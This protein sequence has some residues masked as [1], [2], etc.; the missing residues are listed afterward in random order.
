MGVTEGDESTMSGAGLFAA[1]AGAAAAAA[2]VAVAVASSSDVCAGPSSGIVSGAEMGVEVDLRPEW[3][4]EKGDS[5]DTSSG[6][7]GKDGGGGDSAG[8]TTAAAAVGLPLRLLV[9][10]FGSSRV[11]RG[12]RASLM[13]SRKCTVSPGLEAH[14]MVASPTMEA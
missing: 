13:L 9:V 14:H 5:A 6:G 10:V 12:S 8:D 2:A 3:T 11:S 7:E 1:R 4:R